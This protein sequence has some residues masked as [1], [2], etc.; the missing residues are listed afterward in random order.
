MRVFIAVLM[1]LVLL[2]SSV[3]STRAT[4]V[5][6]VD[7]AE[8]TQLSEWI[9]NARV[10]GIAPADL[11]R[12]GRGLFTDV[13]LEID[14]VYKGQRVPARY[15]LRLAG[16]VGADG[17]A[18]TVPGMPVF[19]RGERV[20]L[21]LERTRDGHVPCGL[22]Q[23]VWRVARTSDGG[24]WV[25]QATHGLHMMARGADGR[26]RTVHAPELTDALPL[27]ALV[28]DVYEAQLAPVPEVPKD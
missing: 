15:V 27:H 19:S 25:Q 5:L 4:S 12:D 3:G 22:G 28:A 26:L 1:P 17:L 16:G 9:V 23:G 18:L 21:F 14:E 24:D 6:A 8:M 13:T 7:V 2:C 11:R 10:V 20:V